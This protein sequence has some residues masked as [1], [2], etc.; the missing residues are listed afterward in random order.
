[1]K[2]VVGCCWHCVVCRFIENG[3]RAVQVVEMSLASRCCGCEKRHA[4]SVVLHGCLLLY[5]PQVAN[6]AFTV[7]ALTASSTPIVG[8]CKKYSLMV[9]VDLLDGEGSCWY[10]LAFERSKSGMR[11]MSEAA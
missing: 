9:A 5:G 10:L 11:S 4:G 1:M 2:I 6:F 3:A 8:A 7:L